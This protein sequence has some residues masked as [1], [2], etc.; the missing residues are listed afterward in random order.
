MNTG[1]GSV[2]GRPVDTIICSFSKVEI[3]IT[4]YFMINEV[5]NEF[6]LIMSKKLKRVYVISLCA[7]YMC[8]RSLLRIFEL[9]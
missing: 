3:K 9:I 4:M 2:E 6:K 1:T 5:I 8:F 7:I